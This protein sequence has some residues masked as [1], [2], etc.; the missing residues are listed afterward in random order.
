[1]YPAATLNENMDE[2]FKN[3]LLQHEHWTVKVSL[4]FQDHILRLS[5]RLP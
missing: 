3:I 5:Q 2:M 1:M 4:G